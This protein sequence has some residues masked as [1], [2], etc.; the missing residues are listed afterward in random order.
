MNEDEPVHRERF[1]LGAYVAGLL[2]QKEGALVA[3]HLVDCPSCRQE[4]DEL[5][6]TS[7]LLTWYADK[8]GEI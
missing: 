6:A 7:D 5:A 3:R 4:R 1:L 8:G 2:D